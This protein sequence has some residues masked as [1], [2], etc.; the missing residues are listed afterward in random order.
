[1]I[2][3]KPPAV[4]PGSFLVVFTGSFTWHIKIRIK[5]IEIFG[6]KLFLNT[7]ESFTEE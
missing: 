4:R 5:C 1:M 2:Q 7:S 3:K 6:I